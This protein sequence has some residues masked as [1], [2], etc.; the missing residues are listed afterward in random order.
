MEDGY[1]STFISQLFGIP[2][3]RLHYWDTRGIVKPSI[4][5]ARGRGSRRLYSYEDIVALEVVT[6]LHASGLSLQKIRKAVAFLRRHF[7]KVERPLSELTFLT[8]GE[9]IFVIT[10]DEGKLVDVLKEH[11]VLSIPIG[12]IAERVR[13]QIEENTRPVVET[14]RVS[15]QKFSVTVERDPETDWYVASC[16]EIPGCVT[17]GKSLDEAR[18]MIRDAIQE[19]LAASREADAVAKEGTAAR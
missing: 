15:G 13:R 1:G 12:R 16:A 3:S 5:P 9:T 19:C 4:R 2:L 7:P 11:F 17:Q 18:T 10:P 6:E 14:V 8:D